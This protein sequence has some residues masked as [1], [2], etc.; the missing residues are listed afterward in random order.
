MSICS[1]IPAQLEIRPN[2]LVNYSFITAVLPAGSPVGLLVGS[3]IVIVIVM[4]PCTLSAGVLLPS[5]FVNSSG[6]VSMV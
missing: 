2:N 1:I 6:L 5:A 4:V 3:I